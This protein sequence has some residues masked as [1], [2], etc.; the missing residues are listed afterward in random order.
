MEKKIELKIPKPQ[1]D[2]YLC[3]SVPE[4]MKTSGLLEI[5]G[6]NKI[7]EFGL[8]SERDRLEELKN[9]AR[10]KVS[11]DDFNRTLDLIKDYKHKSNPET[12]IEFI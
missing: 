5:I 11:T 12:Y 3:M 9:H 2:V 4:D 1:G 10:Y 6:A 7:T 8:L